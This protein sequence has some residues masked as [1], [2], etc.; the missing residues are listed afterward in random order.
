MAANI[1]MWDWN[2][3]QLLVAKKVV[4]NVLN[5]LARGQRSHHN[6]TGSQTQQL[7]SFLQ[8][9]LC[10]ANFASTLAGLSLGKM[11]PS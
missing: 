2:L 11:R 7:S 4:I 8:I 5:S 3:T 10:L 1:I 6:Q 9:L